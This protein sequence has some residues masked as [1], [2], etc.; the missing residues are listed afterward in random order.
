MAQSTGLP[1]P[2]RY[3][4]SSWATRFMRSAAAVLIGFCA[5]GPGV[6]ARPR[7][8][9]PWAQRLK[10]PGRLVAEQRGTRRRSRGRTW[11]DSGSRTLLSRR[12]DS[13][14]NLGPQTRFSRASLPTCFVR[15]C[16]SPPP[17]R[18]TLG[19]PQ[20]LTPPPPFRPVTQVYSPS[21]PSPST[22]L[23]ESR[24]RDSC[25]RRLDYEMGH[26]SPP[27]LSTSLSRDFPFFTMISTC[28]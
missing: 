25:N 20:D 5:M 12:Q 18:K 8:L 9:R 11:R 23:N 1:S 14:D 24:H 28:K 17:L 15:G 21:V 16:H 6:F 2:G 27:L 13:K 10:S 19:K 7:A 4:I 22:E 3:Q 26:P